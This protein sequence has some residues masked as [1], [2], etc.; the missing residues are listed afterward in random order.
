MSQFKVI[1]EQ[2]INSIINPEGKT[3][4]VQFVKHSVPD[5]EASKKSGKREF[6]EVINIKFFKS[7]LSVYEVE[8]TE[9]HKHR[10]AKQWEQFKNNQEQK[11]SGI[12]IGMLPNIRKVEIDRLESNRIYTIE[13]LVEAPMHVLT[14]VGHGAITL[15]QQAKA[16]LEQSSSAELELKEVKAQMEALQKQLTEKQNDTSVDGA[17]RSGRNST[18]RATSNNNK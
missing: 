7:K 18:V 12:A 16:Y 14:Q 3:V 6:K 2:V 11:E 15:Q 8:A 1:E 17:K 9:E 13:R 5:V 4:P 10:Y